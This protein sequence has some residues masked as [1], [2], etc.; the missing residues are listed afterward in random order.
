MKPT[1]GSDGKTITP[2]N[3][4]NKQAKSLPKTGEEVSSTIT[5]AGITALLLA[6]CI[7]LAKRRQTKKQ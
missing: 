1:K 3:G 6:S 4:N 2:E 5:F 7:W